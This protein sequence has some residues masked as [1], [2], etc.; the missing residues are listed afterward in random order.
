MNSF[1]YINKY[2]TE[3]Q[4]HPIILHVQKKPGSG[5]RVGLVGIKSH[6]GRRGVAAAIN[7]PD[8]NRKACPG[9]AWSLC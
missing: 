7:N 2:D 6:Y 3:I 4:M 5:L 8:A 1:Q 9:K